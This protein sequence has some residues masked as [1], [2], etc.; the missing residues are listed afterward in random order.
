MK[1]NDSPLTGSCSSTCSFIYCSHVSDAV[2]FSGQVNVIS[3]VSR[4]VDGFVAW[5]PAP[6]GFLPG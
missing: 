2:S 5:A 6:Q 3:G 1:R 4:D